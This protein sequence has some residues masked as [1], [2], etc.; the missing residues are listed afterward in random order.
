MWAWLGGAT[1]LALLGYVIRRAAQPIDMQL[2]WHFQSKA[3]D[4]VSTASGATD[5]ESAPLRVVTYNIGYASGRENNRGLCLTRDEV[6]AHLD[7]IVFTLQQ[8]NADVIVLQEV[9]WQS[10]RG[11]DIN[12]L[13][14]CCERL[15]HAHWAF[16]VTW[17]VR[18]LPWPFGPPRR[19]YGRVISGQ[20]VLSRIP[21]ADHTVIRFPKP[22]IYPWWHNWFYLDRVVQQVTF[23]DSR[24][25]P[26]QLWHAHLE[27]YHR[28]T[29]VAQIRQCADAIARCGDIPTLITGDFNADIATPND[30]ADWLTQHTTFRTAA[31]F[32]APTF[33]SWAPRETLDQIF[34]SPHWE[35]IRYA[36]VSAPLASDHLPV[37][38][39]YARRSQRT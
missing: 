35:C 18:Y 21:I 13:E 1:A 7:Q 30:A 10:R 39:E 32:D 3:A 5:T 38:G 37:V 8:L 31:A 36:T 24:R 15:H 20:V 2:P 23:A 27:A 29:R 17:N 14:Y 4:S 11:C 34:H 33:P 28:G 6:I 26:W 19:W 16:A 9:D 25:G 12:Q 22:R